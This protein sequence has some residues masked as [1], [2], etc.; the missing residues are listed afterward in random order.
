MYDGMRDGLE[1]AMRAA[2]GKTHVLRVGMVNANHEDL[3]PLFDA[4]EAR[5]PTSDVKFR[6]VNFGDPFGPLRAGAVDVQIVWLPVRE[7]D[8]TVGPVVYIEPVV[9]AMGTGHRLAGRRSVC[10]EDLA[11]EVV[12]GGAKPDYWR[13]V[14]VPRHTPSGR[15][16]PIGPTATSSAEMIS[17]LNNGEAVSPVHAH[18]VGADLAH[19]H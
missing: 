16:I 7:T 3:R 10:Y 18:A 4:F 15:S 19:G 12:M 2:Q 6:Y 13:D 8:L 9:L 11:D 1:R 14:L 5:H 17:L